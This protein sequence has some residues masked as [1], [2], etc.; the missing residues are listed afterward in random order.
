MWDKTFVLLLVV[1]VLVGVVAYDRYITEQGEIGP[2]GK[3]LDYAGLAKFIDD[4]QQKVTINSRSYH[5][6][7]K[8]NMA[9]LQERYVNIETQR[10]T[11]VEN[12][13]KILSQLTVWNDQVESEAAIYEKAILA[14]KQ[15]FLEY[16]PELERLGT[17]LA[18]ISQEPD[19]AIRQ[20][21]YGQ[22]KRQLLALFDELVSQSEEAR[23]RLD[24]I[25]AQLD[26]I[27]GQEKAEVIENCGSL[28]QCLTDNLG[29]L[30]SEL[31]SIG[32]SVVEQPSRDVDQF[33][34]LLGM[35]RR[36]HHVFSKNAEV[37]E[38]RLSEGSA[39]IDSELKALTEK[40]DDVSQG[41][42]A[43]LSRLYEEL[44][45]EQVDLTENLQL[46]L[47][48]LSDVHA[49]AE[50]QFAEIVASLKKSPKVDRDRF[51]TNYYQWLQE[52]RRSL[53]DLLKNETDL[54]LGFQDR[55]QGN[56]EFIDR[57]ALQTGNDLKKLIEARAQVIQNNKNSLNSK[58]D[59][60]ESIEQS[61]RMNQARS[62]PAATA[63]SP[64]STRNDQIKQQLQRLRQQARDRG[65]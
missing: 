22:T 57:L 56:A 30:E 47:Q 54:K 2:V 52:E 8:D 58:I 18:R 39:R 33:S 31:N 15:R 35:L 5:L 13:E 24:E 45:R 55:W 7:L 41:D 6:R 49:K 21:Q 38:R 23:T 60:D 9:R 29:Q 59:L 4:P 51:L 48:R 32:Q 3:I 12:R 40:L 28:K 37:S 14:E 34:K 62:A 11:L 64:L 36:E 1:F 10:K 20:Q 19:P 26:L 53:A 61:R 43:E 63:N 16:S 44:W 42:L 17:D 65:F 46:N 50:K 27:I 25:V